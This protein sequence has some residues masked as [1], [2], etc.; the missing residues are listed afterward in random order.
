MKWLKGKVID[1]I[2]DNPEKAKEW[3]LKDVAA[4]QADVPLVVLH[5]KGG[6][7][8]DTINDEEEVKMCVMVAK[9]GKGG[10]TAY[11]VSES[12]KQDFI[13][14]LTCDDSTTKVKFSISGILHYEI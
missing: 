4:E 8:V 11:P 10:V 1:L 2:K 3:L 9:K 12:A 7:T 14:A 6:G 13:V 5:A